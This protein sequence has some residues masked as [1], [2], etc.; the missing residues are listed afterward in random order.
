MYK[1]GNGV[2]KDPVAA[3][4]L[5]G[6]AARSGNVAAEVEYAI[7][8]FNGTGL[9]KD[10]AAGAALFRKAAY[11]GNAIAQNRLARI[12]ATGRGLPPDP[13]GATKWHTIAKAG[14]ASD[15]WLESYLQKIKDS[16]RAAGED[17]A[18]LWLAHAKPNS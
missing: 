10:E 11:Q 18:R 2:P 16:E 13:I 4:K 15:V 1:D 8:L 3:A 12:L 6:A 17:A 14:G 5:L 9:P 7:A